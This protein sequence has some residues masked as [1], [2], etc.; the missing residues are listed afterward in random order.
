[1]SGSGS[2]ELSLVLACYQEEGHLVE[3]VREIEATLQAAGYDY[4]LI[5]IDDCSRDATP[6]IVAGLCADEPRRRCVLHP[7]NV[8]RG[9][10]VAEGFRLARGRIVGFLDVDL[11]VH[12][13]YLPQMVDAIRA[14]RDGATAY[15]EYDLEWTP[16]ALAR[17]LMSRG[18]RLLFRLL[19]GAPF[20]DTEAGFKFFVRERIL[21]VLDQTENRGW[22]WDTEIMV[23]AH[24]AG[25]DLVELPC[26][27]VRRADK[28][29]TV[30][31]FR[32]SWDYLVALLRFRRRLRCG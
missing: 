26:R 5:L 21:P 25:L 13:R 19:L 28:K 7:R 14:G 1:M 18:Y 12:C 29:S 6:R 3:S 15:R 11:E 30:R 8:G 16:S 27:F 10:T 22:F 24:R 20:R 9:G 31:M 4:E 17:Y 2:C 32:D 23:L